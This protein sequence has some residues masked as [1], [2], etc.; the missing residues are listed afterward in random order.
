MERPISEVKLITGSV[1]MYTEVEG[2][3]PSGP[4]GVNIEEKEAAYIRL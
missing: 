1:L 4:T 2:S 3:S